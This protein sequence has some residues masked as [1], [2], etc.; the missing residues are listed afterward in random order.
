MPAKLAADVAL[1][2]IV[3]KC[4]PPVPQHSIQLL[5]TRLWL[6]GHAVLDDV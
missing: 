5:V 4:F 3:R 1:L 6:E 2:R